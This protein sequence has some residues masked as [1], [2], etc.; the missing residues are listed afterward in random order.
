MSFPEPRAVYIHVPFCVHRCGYCD[1][2][3]VANRDDLIGDYLNA[4]ECEM[5]SLGSIRE[6][7]TLFFG[8]GTPTQLRAE[9]LQR[10]FEIVNRWFVVTD[11]GE[12]STE[13]NPDGLSDAKIDVLADAGVNRVSLGIQSFD[14]DTLKTLE[15]AHSPDDIR[16]TVDRVRKR[17][18]NLS[19]DLIFGVPGQTLANWKATLAET[20]DCG[21]EHISTYGLT[22]EK[23]TAFWSRRNKGDIVPVHQETERAMYQASMETLEAAGFAQYEL[24]NF[25]REGYRCRHNETY[26]Q[27]MPYFAFGPGAAR[28]VDG[29]RE[30]NHRSVFT[31][32]DR[33]G[34]GESVIAEVE[35]MTNQERAHEAL[36]LGLRRIEG[37]DRTE[38]TQRFG[39]TIEDLVGSALQRHIDLGN[40]VDDGQKVR[41]TF[42][43]RFIADSVVVDFL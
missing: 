13:A 22:Y 23:G 26:W 10:L 3:L 9:E 38:L 31:W 32:L 21:P 33:V 30:T 36:M 42:E 25:A 16:T 39:A 37:I 27:A 4:L 40:L 19:L 43:G 1:F 11:G 20:I 6:V 29:R 12:V 24:S 35:E 14:A 5:E 41:L 2:T 15:R 18:D 28:Y 34:K 8:G 17:I 7:D